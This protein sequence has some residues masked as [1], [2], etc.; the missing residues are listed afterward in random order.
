M[1]DIL[2]YHTGKSIIG[3]TVGKLF[4]HNKVKEIYEFRLKAL[5]DIF[6]KN[7]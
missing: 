1:T 5:N 2:H 6:Q 4:V 7:I 3:W